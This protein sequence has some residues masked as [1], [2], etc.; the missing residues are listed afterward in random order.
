VLVQGFLYGNQLEPVAE[1]DGSG[2][3][4]ARFVYGSKAHVPDYMVKAGV[5]YRII[6]D[7]VGSVRLVVNTTDGSIAQRMDYDEF[8]VVTNDTGTGFQPFS[9]AGG[10]Y[11]QHTKLTRFGARD[12]DPG[13][14]RWTAKD[15]IGFAAGNANLYAYA[16]GDPINFVDPDGYSE[17]SL[18]E[19]IYK[20][21]T[22]G[23]KYEEEKEQMNNEL[24]HCLKGGS[25]NLTDAMTRE[26]NQFRNMTN[27]AGEVAGEAGKLIYK[28]EFGVR[29]KDKIPDNPTWDPKAC[30][31]KE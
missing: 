16:I 4:V 28:R 21:L 3:L 5:T 12:Y 8:G 24:E 25:C 6:S 17:V 29:F 1:L 20:F 13:T 7:H 14:G 26:R 19:K 27:A 10:I 2:N 11:D 15:S 30:P 22:E 9:F 18:V 31:K 23:D